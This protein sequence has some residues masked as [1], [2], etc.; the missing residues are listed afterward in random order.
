MPYDLFEH[1]HRFSVWA[2]VRAAQRGFTTGDNLRDA[3]QSTDIVSFVREHATDQIDA[4]GFAVRHCEWC[5]RITEF[6][7]DAGVQNVSFGR[8]AKLVAVYLKSMVV[9][10]PHAGTT[11]AQVAHPPIDRLLLQ[12]LS[13]LDDVPTKA[14][15][16]FRTTNWTDLDRVGYYALVDQIRA[17]VPDVSPFWH[18]EK[19]WKVTQEADS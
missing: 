3:L 18:L 14:R 9:V 19:H 13:R 11:L 10:G 4:D 17:S 5:G 1:R 12:A 7:I 8:A 2:A 15:R 6:L 16:V